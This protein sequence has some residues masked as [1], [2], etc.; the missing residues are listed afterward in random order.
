MLTDHEGK[1]P[2]LNEFY[3]SYTFPRSQILFITKML[4]V[5]LLLIREKIQN[6]IALTCFVYV[7]GVDVTFWINGECLK[8]HNMD[9]KEVVIKDSMVDLKSALDSGEVRMF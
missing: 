1:I 2:P 9:F 5:N 7:A 8:R 6:H 4:E 3:L